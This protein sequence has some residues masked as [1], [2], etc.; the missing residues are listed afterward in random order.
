MSLSSN[1]AGATTTK[2]RLTYALVTAVVLVA[3]YLSRQWSVKGSFVHDY[4]GDAIW[5]AMIYFGYRCLLA[6]S[7]LKKALV[8]ALVTTWLIEFSQLIQTD[9][10]HAVRH[11]KLGGLIL[12]Y[13]FLWS[14]LVMYSV[15]I[16]LAWW[17]DRFLSGRRQ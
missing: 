14:D 13:V 8:A 3:G 9:A 17:G 10:L 12:G 5:A 16:G 2:R 1:P 6:G 11:T 15:G 4:V 7:P